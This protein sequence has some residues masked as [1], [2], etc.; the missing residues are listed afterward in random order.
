MILKNEICTL[1]AGEIY[2]N[3]IIV[4]IPETEWTYSMVPTDVFLCFC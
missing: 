2:V 1:Y 4:K 3:G